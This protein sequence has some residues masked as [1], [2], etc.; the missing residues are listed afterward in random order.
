MRIDEL[1]NYYHDKYW[2]LISFDLTLYDRDRRYSRY[3]I[4][5]PGLVLKSDGSWDV[6]MK[7]P[8]VKSNIM[9]SDIR[10]AV[11]DHFKRFPGY[12][13]KLVEVVERKTKAWEEKHN[14]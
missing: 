5:F 1:I 2:I 4:A 13:E 10:K 11:N 8:V 6:D 9:G 7:N 12:K 14:G 3:K